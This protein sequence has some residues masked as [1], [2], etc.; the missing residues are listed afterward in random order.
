MTQVKA[1]C[2]VKRGVF[3]KLYKRDG[4]ESS[5]K[6]LD[7]ES[8]NPGATASEKEDDCHGKEPSP[9]PSG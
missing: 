9:E 6:E 5:G 2:E 8:D 7:D 3:P 1:L 4:L